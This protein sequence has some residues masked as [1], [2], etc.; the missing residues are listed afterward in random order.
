MTKTRSSSSNREFST[1]YN[2][3]SVDNN[4]DYNAVVL[5]DR[6]GPGYARQSWDKYKIAYGQIKRCTITTHFGSDYRDC[7]R[8]ETGVSL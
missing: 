5:G 8:L 4:D 2:I 1:V 7:W 3:V 6:A